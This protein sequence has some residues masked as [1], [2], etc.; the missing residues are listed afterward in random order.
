MPKH[1]K[2]NNIRRSEMI[3][4]I[5]TVTYEQGCPNGEICYRLFYSVVT[6]II[7]NLMYCDGTAQSYILDGEP[8]QM[9]LCTTWQEI[10]DYCAANNLTIDQ[11]Q[12]YY[13]NLDTSH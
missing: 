10:L 7:D 6:N 8:C 13:Q 9:F 1:M 11:T 5:T 3:L 2:V 12:N 4:P